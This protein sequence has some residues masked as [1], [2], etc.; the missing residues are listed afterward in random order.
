[1]ASIRRT[2]RRPS[3]PERRVTAVAAR[4]RRHC[5]AG[6]EP[7]SSHRR[8][9][10]PLG[11]DKG[12]DGSPERIQSLRPRSPS[13]GEAAREMNFPAQAVRT[14]PIPKLRIGSVGALR[15][16]D[17]QRQRQASSD[18]WSPNSRRCGWRARSPAMMETARAKRPNTKFEPPRRGHYR[19][20]SLTVRAVRR[21]Q[22]AATSGPSRPMKR[23]SATMTAPTP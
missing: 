14:Q 6:R 16:R 19:W 18:L 7:S 2:L 21:S 10:M 4:A 22:I 5:S 20:S 15:A 12:G 9:S 8:G 23:D 13:V 1:M 17:L 3:H 11:R